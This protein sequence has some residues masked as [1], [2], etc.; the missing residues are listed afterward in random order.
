MQI[1]IEI[2]DT[3]KNI[4]DNEDT[5]TFSHIIWQALLMDAIKNGQPLPKGHGILVDMSE[6]IVKLM[7]YYDRDKTIGQCLDE[8][9][10][11]IETDGGDAE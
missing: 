5:K 9:H 8:V 10:T 7:Q 11:V 4:A 2:S 6:V 3:L 1:V